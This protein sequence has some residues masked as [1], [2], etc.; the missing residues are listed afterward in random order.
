M[1]SPYQCNT[2]GCARRIESEDGESENLRMCLEGVLFVQNGEA[3]AV[4]ALRDEKDVG[5][6]VR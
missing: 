4:D 3:F 6:E 5:M 2:K 1:Q